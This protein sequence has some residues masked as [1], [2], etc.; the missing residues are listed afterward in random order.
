[1]K[2]SAAV[3]ALLF[4]STSAVRV[5]GPEVLVKPTTMENE[6]ATADLEFKDVPVGG[7]TVSFSQKKGVPVHVNPVLMT[8]T[9]GDATL[10]MKIVVGPDEVELKKKR[11]QQQQQ[12]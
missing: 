7:D 11:E 9:M 12:Q 1:M 4:A 2:T 6:A 3:L 10:G 8:D 5:N